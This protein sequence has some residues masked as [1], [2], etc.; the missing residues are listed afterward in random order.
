MRDAQYP[1]IPTD[2]NALVSALV[3]GYERLTGASVQ[4]ASPEKL[5]IQ[6]VA[7]VLLQERALNNYTG[8]QN[9]P[10]RASGENLDAR[11][12]IF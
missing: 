4:P 7:D 12:G 1:F 10:S 11:E 9:I 3:S 5:F 8:N 2:A 6:W